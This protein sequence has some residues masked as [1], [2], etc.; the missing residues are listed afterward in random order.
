MEGQPIN[1][2]LASLL[3]SAAVTPAAPGPSGEEDPVVNHNY[4]SV[5]AAKLASPPSLRLP[6]GRLTG[7]H[8]PSS[9]S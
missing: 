8:Q 2:F 7:P 5:S 3:H 6:A 1:P 9:R 4:S